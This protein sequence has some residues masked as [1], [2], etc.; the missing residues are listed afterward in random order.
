MDSED[1]V[2]LGTLIEGPEIDLIELSGLELTE[3]EQQR[4]WDEITPRRILVEDL[5]CEEIE[6]EEFD[7]APGLSDSVYEYRCG[8]R[9]QFIE[10]LRKV[11]LRYTG[12]QAK[13]SISIP[14]PPSSN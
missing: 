11:L 9:E 4:I 7:D 14:A 5:L 13:L 1:F 3:E 2:I 10:R 6:I 12:K 8:P